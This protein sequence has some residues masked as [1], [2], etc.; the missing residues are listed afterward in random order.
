MNQLLKLHIDNIAREKPPVN[1][2]KGADEATIYLYDI[3]DSDFGASALAMVSAI[4]QA[5]NVPTLNIR[6][7]SPGGSVFESR[8][9]MAAIKNY[10]GKT[11]AHIDSL[12]AS[13][14]TSVAL[15]CDEVVMSSG[16]LFMV[17]NASAF[18]WGDKTELRETADLLQK[19]ELS[20]IK[21][22]T[23]KTG[24]PDAEII[25]MMD[26]ETWLTCDECMAHGFIDRVADGKAKPA[27]A[28]NL[29]AFKNAPTAK[30][31]PPPDPVKE[32]PKEP[33]LAAGFFT[34]ATN[35]NRLT[36]LS[37]Q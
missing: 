4:A 7:N 2:S 20:I 26:A 34:S 17:H 18:A 14:A 9:M 13:A 36:L 24:K 6:I 37:I 3:I 12:C 15:S 30:S 35:Q 27:N 5:G 19:I 29:A 21:D 23:D 25:A 32:T 28:W 31:E 22:Y 8:A 16:A 10:K 1:V 11:I 33:A